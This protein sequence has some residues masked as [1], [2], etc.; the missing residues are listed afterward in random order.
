MHVCVCG[1]CMGVGVWGWEG[2]GTDLALGGYRE[3][4]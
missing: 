2:M 3:H 1:Q 4:R